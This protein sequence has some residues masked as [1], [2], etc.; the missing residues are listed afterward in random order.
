MALVQVQTTTVTSATGYVDLIGTTTDDVY[1]IAFN[2]VQPTIDNTQLIC[3]VL[4][5]SSPDTSANYDRAAIQFLAGGSGANNQYNT[6]ET[7][8]YISG[9]QSGTNTS[10][11]NQGIL[12]LYNFNNSSEFT[13]A[14]IDPVNRNASGTLY[15]MQGGWVHTVAQSCNGLR[16]YYSSGNIA[17]GTFTLFKQ[18]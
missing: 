3:R 5:S 8:T 17:K 12:Y 6:N 13:Y 1:M 14:V 11:T 7:F 15:G 10:E 9:A 18:V 4:V 16:I 2:N